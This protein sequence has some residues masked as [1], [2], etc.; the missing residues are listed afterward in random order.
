MFI[1]VHG[2]NFL[3]FITKVVTRFH[4]LIRS[5]LSSSDPRTYL[6]QFF[7]IKSKLLSL[8]THSFTFPGIVTES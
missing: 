8:P 3:F 5:G 1:E 6:F 4:V 2:G 7:V